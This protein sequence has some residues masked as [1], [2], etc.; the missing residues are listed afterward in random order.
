MESKRYTFFVY[1][2]YSRKG[3]QLSLTIIFL[4]VSFLNLQIPGL[5]GR[6]RRSGSRK[7]NCKKL[8]VR[9]KVDETP[10]RRYR[11]TESSKVK[12]NTL[13]L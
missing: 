5:L 8:R 12:G 1:S 9:V 3:S 11:S 7:N 10:N 13:Q 4:G 6:R 2:S